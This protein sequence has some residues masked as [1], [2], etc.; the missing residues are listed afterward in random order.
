MRQCD[1]DQCGFCL[2]TLSSLEASP[3]RLNYYSVVLPSVLLTAR[4]DVTSDFF[5]D[6]IYDTAKRFKKAS[7][8]PSYRHNYP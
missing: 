2:F 3:V 6:V 8:F 4:A 7:S 1:P 5:A